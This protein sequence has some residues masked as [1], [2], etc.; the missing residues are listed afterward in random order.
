[1]TEHRMPNLWFDLETFSERPI[2]DGSYRYAEACEVMLWA[3]ADGDGD[4][5]VWD[6]VNGTLNYADEFSGSWSKTAS[7]RAAFCRRSNSRG[8]SRTRT[9]SCGHIT[10]ACLTS[11]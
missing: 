11:R 6:L 8:S 3:W 4:V 1:M 10:V 5:K 7:Q 2:K 9:T